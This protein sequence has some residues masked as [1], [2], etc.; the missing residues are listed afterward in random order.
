MTEPEDMDGRAYYE[1]SQDELEGK[2][3]TINHQADIIGELAEEIKKL[4]FSLRIAIISLT[5]ISKQPD[6][7]NTLNV[8]QDIAK[9]TLGVLEE[10]DD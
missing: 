8:N 7:T 1:W 9:L 6:T 2:D 5:Q 3:E 10:D 4:N